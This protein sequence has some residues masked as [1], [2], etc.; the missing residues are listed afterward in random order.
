MS[1][2]N[3]ALAINIVNIIFNTAM[4]FI[5]IFIFH[6]PIFYVGLFF[7]LLGASVSSIITLLSN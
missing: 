3:K 4:V 7:F 6:S 5:S 1:T 2:K